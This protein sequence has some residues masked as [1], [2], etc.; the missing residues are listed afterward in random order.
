M[1]VLTII[2]ILG[3]PFIYGNVGVSPS[4]TVSASYIISGELHKDDILARTAMADATNGYNI[5]NSLTC[6][7]AIPASLTT[8]VL[9]PDIYCRTLGVN[10]PSSNI[11]EL[12]GYNNTNSVFIFQIGGKF[13]Y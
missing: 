8:R 9:Y 13:V 12:N 5:L 3:T 6:N 7:Q 10:V 1:A 4:T 11:I 2:L